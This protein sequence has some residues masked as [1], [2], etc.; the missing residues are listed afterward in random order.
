M[1]IWSILWIF[2]IFCDHLVHIGLIWY[3]FSSFGIMHQEKS[4]NPDSECNE[5]VGVRILLAFQP[6]QKKK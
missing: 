4:G 2:R 3:I 5:E 6:Q 1:T